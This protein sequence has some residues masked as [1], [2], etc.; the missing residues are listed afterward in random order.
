MR[1]CRTLLTLVAVCF[2]GCATVKTSTIAFYKPEFRPAGTIAVIAFDPKVRESLE[3]AQYKPKF[4]A[5]LRSVGYEIVDPRIANQIAFVAYGIDNGQTET[6]SI[7]LMGQTGGGTSFTSGTIYSDYGSSTFNATTYTMPQYGVVGMIPRSVRTYNRSIA[8][9]FVDGV[10]LL[11]NEPITLMELR[12]KST[13]TCGE[14]SEVID[15]M[16]E[17][18]FKDF[19]PK[20]GKQVT[21]SISGQF[22]C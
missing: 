9:N 15:E 21:R 16:L 20:N 10:S 8:V 7:P 11:K 13:G 3:W 4:E 19:P 18:T 2:A 17:A 1:K 14:I 5:S 6:V 12:T 22:D